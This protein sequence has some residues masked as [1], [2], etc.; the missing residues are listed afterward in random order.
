MTM[1]LCLLQL[2]QYDQHPLINAFCS[3]TMTI[4]SKPF[5]SARFQVYLG[6]VGQLSKVE[7][8]VELHCRG[9]EALHHIA[10]QLDGGI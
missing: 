4:V 3:M 5:Q 10:V 7:L 8:V 6:D 2:S 1:A 9:Q